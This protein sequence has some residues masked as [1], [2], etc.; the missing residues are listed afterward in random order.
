MYLL[1]PKEEIE[2]IVNDITLFINKQY[3]EIGVKNSLWEHI[4]LDDDGAS[5]YGN[6]YSTD[7]CEKISDYIIKELETI[8]KMTIKI[9]KEKNNG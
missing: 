5:G 9:E 6:L 4:D 2:E 3:A 7:L 8:I 1:V